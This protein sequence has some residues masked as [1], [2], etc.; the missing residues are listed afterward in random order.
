MMRKIFTVLLCILLFI[1]TICLAKEYF[2]YG[3]ASMSLSDSW[4]QNNEIHT[5]AE[6]EIVDEHVQSQDYGYFVKD[7]TYIIQYYAGDYYNTLSE[8]DKKTVEKEKLTWDSPVLKEVVPT[9]KHLSDVRVDNNVKINGIR[10]VME[11]KN[12]GIYYFKSYKLI[13]N[14][15]LYTFTYTAMGNSGKHLEE[16]ETMV[17]S[18][19]ITGTTNIVKDRWWSWIVTAVLL[20]IMILTVWGL[21]Q[22]KSGESKS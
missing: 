17:R 11:E 4:R 18:F 2:L 9:D 3:G 22:K 7:D 21:R 12:T 8:E 13:A 19:S 10:A 16:F 15:N 14:G 6:P 1:P 20:F 5:N